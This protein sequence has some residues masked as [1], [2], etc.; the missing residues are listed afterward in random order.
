M[1]AGFFS[2]IGRSNDGASWQ[3]RVKYSGGH[4]VEKIIKIIRDRQ[5]TEGEKREE[6]N[7]AGLE[8]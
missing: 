3:K 4:F 7:K 1:S 8:A 2:L 5:G 6:R